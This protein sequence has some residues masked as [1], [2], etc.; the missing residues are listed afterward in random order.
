MSYPMQSWTHHCC[1]PDVL[2]RAEVSELRQDC[3]A[4]TLPAGEGHLESSLSHHRGVVAITATS[5]VLFCC[6]TYILTLQLQHVTVALIAVAATQ[7]AL[8]KSKETIKSIIVSGAWAF[9]SARRLLF[10]CFAV[11][12]LALSRAREFVLFAN[13]GFHKRCRSR[14]C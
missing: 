9:H 5:T 6:C 3:A 11:S 12:K 4:A 2:H 1:G 8:G 13:V 10:C 7:V 14:E